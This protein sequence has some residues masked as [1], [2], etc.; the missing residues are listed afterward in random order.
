MSANSPL[1]PIVAVHRTGSKVE[2]IEFHYGQLLAQHGAQLYGVDFDDANRRVI[3]H[4]QPGAQQ[5]FQLGTEL[6]VQQA[7]DTGLIPRQDASP[8][9]SPAE[10]PSERRSVKART[11]RPV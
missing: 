10:S 1:K 5:D 4:C 8:A 2:R 6:A 9:E 11:S 3:L 7:I